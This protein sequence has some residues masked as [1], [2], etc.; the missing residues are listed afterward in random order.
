MYFISTPNFL[1]IS[2]NEKSPAVVET[3]RAVLFVCTRRGLR[4]AAGARRGRRGSTGAPNGSGA[5]CIDFSKVSW[6]IYFSRD[7]VFV[8]KKGKVG[9]NSGKTMENLPLILVHH[10]LLE[11]NLV[12]ACWSHFGAIQDSTEMPPGLVTTVTAIFVSEFVRFCLVAKT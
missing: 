3:H 4:E 9:P 2:S 10:G 7:I 1:Q 8:G 12:G 6:F 5:S 11:P